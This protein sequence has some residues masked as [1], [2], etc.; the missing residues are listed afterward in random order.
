MTDHE[1]VPTEGLD[2]RIDQWVR[3]GLITLDQATAIRSLETQRLDPTA[4]GQA[5]ADRPGDEKPAPGWII[6]EVL[7]YLG[8][9][10]VVIAGF[11]LVAQFWEDIPDAARVAISLAAGILLAVTGMYLDSN[12]R[13]SVRRAGQ[14]SLLLGAAPIGLAIGMLADALFADEE[15]SVLVGFAGA[16][17]FSISF[18]RRG[19][20]SAQHLALFLSA[21]GTTMAIGTILTGDEGSWVIGI[22][23][24]AL[25]AGWTVA[26]ATGHLPPRILAEVGGTVALGIGS[27]IVVGSLGSSGADGIAAMACWVLVSIVLIGFGVARDRVVPIIGG[28]L[29]LVI[30]IPWMIGQAL[31]AV[32]ILVAGGILIATAIYLTRRA[33]RT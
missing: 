20:S 9:V 11:I 30:Y 1:P 12:R 25:G 7:A 5:R 32:H 19:P 21:L 26:S 3:D 13:A 14:V 27:L 28:V 23:I 29:G 24:V 18:Y 17:T 2:A 8:A 16:L 10:F 15:I 33:D 6:R 4:V 22:L 31:G